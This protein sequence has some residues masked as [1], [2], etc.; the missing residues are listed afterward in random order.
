MDIITYTSSV[1]HDNPQFAI[2]MNT[3]VAAEYA[4][5][6]HNTQKEFYQ[7]M[8]C[9]KESWIRNR[10]EDAYWQNFDYILGYVIGSIPRYGYIKNV[11]LADDTFEVVIDLLYGT[12][13]LFPV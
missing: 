2:E 11:H 4:D 9:V 10:G 13:A 1:L 5:K 7:K 3:R 8:E 12:W 6:I